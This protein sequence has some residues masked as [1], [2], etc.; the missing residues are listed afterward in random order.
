VGK[1]EKA[2]KQMKQ[3]NWKIF[4]NHSRPQQ[5]T[6]QRRRTAEQTADTITNLPVSAAS[7]QRIITDNL[8]SSDD[9]IADWLVRTCGG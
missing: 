2:A 9:T 5:T 1:W 8:R 3:P 6:E 4:H 7:R